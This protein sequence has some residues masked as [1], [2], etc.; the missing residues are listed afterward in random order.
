[1]IKRFI[2]ILKSLRLK[3]SSH[4][5]MIELD[6]LI[7]SSIYFS[8][9]GEYKK[10]ETYLQQAAILM[11]SN[12]KIAPHIGRVRFLRDRFSDLKTQD[13]TKKMLEQIDL[14]NIELKRKPIYFP[15][16]FWEGVGRFHV[17]VLEQYGVENFK[18]TVSHHYQNWFMDSYNDPQVRQLFNTWPAN[19]ALEP[20]TNVIEIPNH[21]GLPTLDDDFKTP[22][23]RLANPESLEIYR[24]SVGLLWEF[25][26]NS[27]AGNLLEQLPELEI[28]NPLRIWRK[29]KLIS[30]DMAHSLRERSMFLDALNLKGNEGL[31]VGE[32]GAGHGRLAEVFGRTT[33]YRHFIFDI[34][35]ALYVSQWYI[36]SIFPNEKIFEFR[37][38][39]DFEEIRSELQECRFAFFTSNQIEMIPDEFFNLFINMNSLA[40]MRLDQIK[41]F[42]SQIDRL[43]SR[44]FLSRQQEKSFNPIELTPLTKND[45]ALPSRWLLILDKLDE[46]YPDYFNQIWTR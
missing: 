40:E 4:R 24:I 18:R 6:K 36:K 42:L 2:K 39:E 27:T 1:M 32:L 20:W 25:V 41:N 12:P 37:H 22:M 45:F 34:A 38:F 19:L 8:N 15:G 30:S 16:E 46:I 21:V 33:N 13:E 31:I 10:A 35:P 26:K 7:A 11:P 5:K 9:Q 23:Y 43:T 17:Q 29:G 3:R 14:M 44:A 28:G